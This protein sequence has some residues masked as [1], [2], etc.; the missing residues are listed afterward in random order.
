MPNGDKTSRYLVG[1]IDD[2]H[3]YQQLEEEKRQVQQQTDL[4][5][6]V[7]GE[8]IIGL[9]KEGR[10]TFVNPAAASILGYGV[11]EMLHK[12]SHQLWHHSHADGSGYPEADCP[13]TGVLQHGGTSHNDHEIFWHKNGS[14]ITVDYI[15]TPILSDGEITG[16]VVVFHPTAQSSKAT[17]G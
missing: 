2:I 17:S 16:A 13:I 1:V 5:L 7:A 4:I 15:S 9:D 8:G 6:K 11:D 10:H 14:A 3:H 12:H